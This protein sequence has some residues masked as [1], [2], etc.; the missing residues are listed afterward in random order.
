M[1]GREVQEKAKGF[2][3][4]GGRIVGSLQVLGEV[5]EHPGAAGLRLGLL[6][7]AAADKDDARSFGQKD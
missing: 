7:G 5:Q 1:V 3:G 4:H 2:P 6:E